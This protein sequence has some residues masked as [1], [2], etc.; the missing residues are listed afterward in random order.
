MPDKLTKWLYSTPS[1]LFL[2][3]LAVGI[4][5]A[6]LSTPYP[7]QPGYADFDAVARSSPTPTPSPTPLLAEIEQRTKELELEIK[8]RK[9]ELELELERSKTAVDEF[10]RQ[11]RHGA[12]ALCRDGTYSYSANRRSACSHHGGVAQWLSR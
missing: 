3:T 2:A 5:S 4:W 1:L 6:N 8:Q 9:K 11:W 10:M 12:T 7:S